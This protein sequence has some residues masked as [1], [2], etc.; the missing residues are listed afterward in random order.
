M[1]EQIYIGN[2]GKGLVTS[3]EPFVIDNDAFPTMFN[4]Y[5]WRGRAKRKR[6]TIFL[7]QLQIQEQIAATPLPWQ[8][9]SFALV[10]GAGNLIVQFALGAS[11]SITPGSLNLIVSG[12]QTYTDLLMNGTLQGSAGGTG[13]IN[14]AT[15][16]FTLSLDLDKYCCSYYLVNSA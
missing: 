9:Q 8:L 6:G 11:A 3:R 10:A 15:G 5:A 2:F 1:P 12:D 16:A 14:Y 4:F 13:T 7:G